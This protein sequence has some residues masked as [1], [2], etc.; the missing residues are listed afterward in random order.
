ME[1]LGVRENATFMSIGVRSF[2]RIRSC[3]ASVKYSDAILL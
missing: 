3:S 1:Q 2:W